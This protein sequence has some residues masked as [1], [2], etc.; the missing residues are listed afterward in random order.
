MQEFETDG[1]ILR[2]I[3]DPSEILGHK[4]NKDGTHTFSLPLRDMCKHLR[5]ESV[6]V[7]QRLVEESDKTLQI[8]L[9]RLLDDS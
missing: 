7:C 1:R 8:A 2:H 9:N 6:G 5:E 4:Q 3:S